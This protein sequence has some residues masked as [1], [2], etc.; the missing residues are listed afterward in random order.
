LERVCA[1]SSVPENDGVHA[2]SE[3]YLIDNGV[4]VIAQ[5]GKDGRI[6]SNC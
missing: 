6:W 2:S 4:Q 5:A 3:G 1:I